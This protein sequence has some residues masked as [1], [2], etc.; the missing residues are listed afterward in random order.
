[1]AYLFT[2][3]VTR[4]ELG[5]RIRAYQVSAINLQELGQRQVTGWEAIPQQYFRHIINSMRQRV[6]ECIHAN[7]GYTSY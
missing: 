1:M 5:R 7:G 6:Q 4:D 2:G 3:L